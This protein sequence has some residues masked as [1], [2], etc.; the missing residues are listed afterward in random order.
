MILVSACLGGENCKY[1]GGNNKNDKVLN[2]L[3]DKDVTYI[4]P[5]EMG[6]LSTPR[7]PAEIQGSAEGILSGTDKILNCD[8]EDVTNEFLIGAKK[9]LEIALENKVTLAVLK[10]KSPSCGKGLVYDG[11]FTGSKIE[12]NGITAEL[13]IK[14]GIKVITEED[15]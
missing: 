6:G 12:G 11:S 3:K 4:C 15:L 1:N 7:K 8:K 13:L 9:C 2:F 5:E 14:N 10:A